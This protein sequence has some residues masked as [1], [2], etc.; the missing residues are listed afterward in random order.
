MGGVQ[1]PRRGGEASEGVGELCVCVDVV[2]FEMQA[3]SIHGV[4]F[5]LVMFS[6]GD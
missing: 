2:I 6:L 5:N 4:G 3:A 1:V